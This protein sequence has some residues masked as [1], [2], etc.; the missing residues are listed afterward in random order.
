MSMCVYNRLGS[1]IT[2]E[3]KLHR[4]QSD[5]LIGSI[6][7]V[8]LFF[9]ILSCFKYYLKEMLEAILLYF[10]NSRGKV[11]LKTILRFGS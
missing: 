3:K 11:T 1:S 8:D 5:F 10:L 6:R 4:H 7:L 9:S 2:R